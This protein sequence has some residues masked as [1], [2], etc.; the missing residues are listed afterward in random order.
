MSSHNYRMRAEFLQL[1]QKAM[2]L[3]YTVLGNPNNQVAS[4]DLMRIHHA[5]VNHP[6]YNHPCTHIRLAT[7]DGQRTPEYLEYES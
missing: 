5:I 1:Q 6:L 2:E 7:I 4:Y 3:A